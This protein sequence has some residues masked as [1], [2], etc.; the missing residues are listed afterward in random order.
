MKKIYFFI[1]GFF[2]GLQNPLILP[3]FAFLGV[4][5]GLWKPP[6]LKK[7]Y[8]FS[9]FSIFNDISAFQHWFIFHFIWMEGILWIIFLKV[10]FLAK[11]NVFYLVKFPPNPYFFKSLATSAE[12]WLIQYCCSIVLVLCQYKNCPVDN[13]VKCQCIFIKKE[14]G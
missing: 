11:I 1:L 14:T 4:F 5:G 10:T 6:K 3:Y 7:I 13:I 8:I 9:L 2:G 12:L